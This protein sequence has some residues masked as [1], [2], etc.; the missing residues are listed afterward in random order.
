MYP[1][2][3]WNGKSALTHA[4]NDYNTTT[5]FLSLNYER[6]FGDHEIKG[7]LF[8]EVF[9][10]KASSFSAFRTNF[11]EDGLDE[12]SFGGQLQKDATGGSYTNARRSYVG[13]LNYNYKEKYLLEASLRA[14]GSV[15]FPKGKKY[16]FF[17]AFS[18]GWRVSEEAFWKDRLVS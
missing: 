9:Q 17:P 6:L 2:G 13:R 16:G 15:A 1:Y 7:L 4:Y 8:T 5:L 14:D 10:S 12:L 3:G 11:P 18:V